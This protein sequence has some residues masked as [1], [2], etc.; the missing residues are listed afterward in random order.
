VRHSTAPLLLTFCAL[1]VSTAWARAHHLWAHTTAG[2]FVGR[3]N[4]PQCKQDAIQ[5][6]GAK[7]VHSGNTMADRESMAEEVLAKTGGTLVHPY[8]DVDVRA[9][10]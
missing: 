2:L 7:L 3:E 4:T 8:N 10:H 1:T 6:Y 9:S 5:G